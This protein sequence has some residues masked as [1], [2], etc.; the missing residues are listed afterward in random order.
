V[1]KPK[2][3]DSAEIVNYSDRLRFHEPNAFLDQ[4]PHFSCH[5]VQLGFPASASESFLTI[6]LE[7]FETL[8]AFQT[9]FSA[10]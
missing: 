10:E 3:A 4:V 8:L 1:C 7:Q 9:Q 6:V 5:L 2:H